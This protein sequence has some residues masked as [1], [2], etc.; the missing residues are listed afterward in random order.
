MNI[1]FVWTSS[2]LKGGGV[3]RVTKTLGSIFRKRAHNVY[4]L[5]F[6]KGDNETVE[7]I[8]Q[9][10]CPNSE[11]I[12]AE[13]NI[14]YLKQLMLENDIQVV[15]NQTGFSDTDVLKSINLAK[16]K[17]NKKPKILTVHHNCIK[18]LYDSF[19]LVVTQNYQNHW[20]R[21]VITNWLVLKILKLR[22]RRKYHDI[23]KYLL[24]N[25]DKLVLLSD[26]FKPELKT[27]SINPDHSKI[28]GIPN[29][30][31]FEAKDVED[32]KENRILYLGR[33]NFQQKRADLLIN[34]W[35]KIQDEFPEWHFDIVGDGENLE[36]LKEMAQKEK[37]ERVHFHGFQHPEP[38]LERAKFF[39]LSSAFEG[40]PMVLVEAQAYGVVPFAFRT[41]S[42]LSD[43]IDNDASGVT[44][45]PFDIGSYT[46]RLSELMSDENSRIEL[47]T[48][49]RNSVSRF[50]PSI[51]ARKW[52]SLFQIEKRPSLQKVQ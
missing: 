20:L 27:Y 50:K 34:I 38:Y 43:V 23:I 40:F 31:P 49:A 21:P 29:P 48:K 30:A 36:E 47:S 37:L 28:T 15:I 41:F 13:E 42:S 7:G 24:E 10:Y 12:C 8:P 46:K 5:S 22:H 1:L 9:F 16:A 32:K 52:E 45:E 51:I 25:S 11:N 19:E 18:C 2:F 39:V 26:K 3:G 44:I 17:V 35:Q 4:Y 14:E 6:S 33:I